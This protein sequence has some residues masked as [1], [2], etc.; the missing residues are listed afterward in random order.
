M[1]IFISEETDNFAIIVLN[2]FFIEVL[3]DW[4][5]KVGTWSGN[6]AH[7]R[8]DS[9]LRVVDSLSVVVDNLAFCSKI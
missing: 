4:E 1:N 3:S 9:R 8:V 2:I 6:I 5:G 7:S